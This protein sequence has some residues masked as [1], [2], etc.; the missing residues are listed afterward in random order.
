MVELDGVEGKGDEVALLARSVW[1]LAGG[2]E[3]W[4][5][6]GLPGPQQA[7]GRAAV[8]AVRVPLQV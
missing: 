8:T 1:F 7:G 6:G 4:A 2:R 5:V 3:G